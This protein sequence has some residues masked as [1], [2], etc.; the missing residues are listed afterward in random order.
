VSNADTALTCAKACEDAQKLVAV[1][2]GGHALP[3]SL[4]VALQGIR[5]AGDGDRLR[6]FTRAL[7]KALEAAR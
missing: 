2:R 6:A 4:H 7:Q 3:D 1:I 5:A